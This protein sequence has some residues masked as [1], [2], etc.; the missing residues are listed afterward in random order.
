MRHLLERV[1]VRLAPEQSDTRDLLHVTNRIMPG[2][3]ATWGAGSG[4]SGAS[5]GVKKLKVPAVAFLP[6]ILETK[7]FSVTNQPAKII[8]H[9]SQIKTRATA[10][11]ITAIAG[12]NNPAPLTLTVSM[13][14]KARSMSLT[15]P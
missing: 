11:A 10:T 3:E 8:R 2:V 14:P 6:P 15:S 5:L 13:S 9:Y 1:M 4:V 7:S 12:T